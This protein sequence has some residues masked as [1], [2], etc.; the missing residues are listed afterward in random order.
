MSVDTA[1]FPHIGDA[2]FNLVNETNWL[3]VGSTVEEVVL[4]AQVAL[5]SYYGG[6]MLGLVAPFLTAIPA[7]WLAC[8]GSTYNEADYPELYA[9]LDD[10]FRD[11]INETFT[12]P[13]MGGRFLSGV[14]GV[15]TLGALGGLASVALTVAQLPA[16]THTYLRPDPAVDVGSVGAPIPGIT[17]ATPGVATGSSGADESHENRPPYL[18]VNYAIFAGRG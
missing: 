4:A 17:S 8:D 10:A 16:H 12:I 5:D 2:I 18:A 9:V 13:D 1:L 11:T 7:G 14:D 3:E 15:D 6:F